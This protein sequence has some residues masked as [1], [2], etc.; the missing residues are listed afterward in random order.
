MEGGGPNGDS[1]ELTTHVDK[2]TSEPVENF[3]KNWLEPKRGSTWKQDRN[4]LRRSLPGTAIGSLLCAF[5]TKEGTDYK[6][7][8]ESKVGIGLQAS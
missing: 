4:R 7:V 3:Y 6:E 5:G 1:L 2:R 8:G